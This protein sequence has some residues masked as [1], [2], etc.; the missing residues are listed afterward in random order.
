M[1]KKKTENA[2]DKLKKH[3]VFTGAAILTVLI[4]TIGL[5]MDLLSGGA[6]FDVLKQN[7]K[8]ISLKSS[9]LF[10]IPFKK[11]SSGILDVAKTSIQAV[12][13][14]AVKPEQTGL[15]ADAKVSSGI[16]VDT[17]DKG[18]TS[19][20]FYQRSTALGTYQGT[21]A[22]RPSYAIISKSRKHR[23]GETGKGLVID[24]K[25]EAGWAGWYTLLDGLDVSDN[26]TLSFW[27]K[28][29]KGQEKFDIG[30]ADS[31]MQELQID[32]IY[33]GDVNS[34]LPLGVT[35]QWQEVKI[36][37]SR[38]G[39]ELDMRDMGSVVLWF[40]YGGKG[41]IFI[42]DM[43]FKV[44][45]EVQEKEAYNLP[46]AKLKP[47]HPRSL[48]V[49]KIDP[50]N[51]LKARKDLFDLCERAAIE[52]IY[53]YFGE[54]DPEQ[55]KEYCKRLAEFLVS[56]HKRGLKIEALTGTPTWALEKF[57]KDCSR[58][59][60]A[61]LKFNKD[62]P[63]NER[64]D[65]ISLDVEPYL[66]TEWQTDRERIKADYIV[67]LEKLRSLIDSYNQDFRFG[68]AISTFYADIDEGRFE[69]RILELVDYI[70]LMDYHDDP[71]KVIEKGK[72]HLEMAKQANK[73]V[74]I[75]VET[76]DLIRLNQG[77]RRF[78]FFEEGWEEMEKRLKVVERA[79]S[80]NPAFEGFAI[81]CYYSYKLLPRAKNIPLK[82]RPK[83]IYEIASLAS[84]E[85]LA[86]D[87]KLDDWDLTKPYKNDKKQKAVYGKAAW[88]GAEDLSAATYS[89]WDEE[90]L[91]FA[92]DV[93]DNSVVQ[94]KK[95][96]QMW[97]G[98][99]IEFWLD[100]ELKR[101]YNESINNYDDF[102]FGF[103]PGNFKDLKPE[104]YVWVP[105]LGLDYKK[106]IDIAASKT[107]TGYI[108]EVK[109]PAELL[110]STIKQKP[111]IKPVSGAKVLGRAQEAIPA[112]FA[113]GM[114][115]GI[116]VDPSDCDNKA[117]PQKCLLSS[118]VNRV[119]GDPTTFGILVLE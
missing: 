85:T 94:E 34:F 33:A 80:R 19:G 79:F 66:T 92:F 69:N 30:L 88:G 100:V 56:S 31:D 64:M 84:K 26:N 67:L 109:I 46:Q 114:K 53:L 106:L 107:D 7:I 90:N 72:A 20:V 112:S 102:Q 11:A 21:W 27:V 70:A 47:K 23:R 103:S 111:G 105:D 25:K 54:F 9:K 32:A 97:E 95:R 52:Y 14:Q 73:Q 108:M 62:R 118:S 43:S 44:D 81:H 99:H 50:I 60:E 93:T 110:F 48:W 1:G 104:V 115:L 4:V 89:M 68:V 38:V 55:E 8:P 51:N 28:G 117:T 96:D 61:F 40:R 75:G 10:D 91:Y 3:P 74:S 2:I 42:D 35:T 63:K 6:I 49:W 17:F 58:W 39:A 45:A 24:Y 13:S 15:S 57:H 41:K 87:G 78:T 5:I 119:W 98:D 36:P 113:K 101:D 77:E 18:M 37:L 29:E 22:K 65:G 82:P 86:I 59:V 116:S 76:Q 16:I 83:K 12:T 71:K